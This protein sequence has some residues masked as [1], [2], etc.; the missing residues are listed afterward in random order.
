MLTLLLIP[1]SAI[2]FNASTILKKIGTDDKAAD[3]AQQ[4]IY[5]L[6]PGVY[7]GSMADSCRRF[8]NSFGLT[9]VPFKI[10]LVA[11]LSIT[12]WAWLY[13]SHLGWGLKGAGLAL[14]SSNLFNLI[15]HLIYMIRV[16]EVQEAVRWP[17]K[18][19]F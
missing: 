7:I 14:L 15:L 17:D 3:N 13:I 6:L 12:F 18:M 9:T 16:E 11:N 5:I 10:E 19:V 8:F 1:S 2:L 4:L